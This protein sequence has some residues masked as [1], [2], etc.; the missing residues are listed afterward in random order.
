MGIELLATD[1]GKHYLEGNPRDVARYE[2]VIP[3]VWE[4]SPECF[5][6][7]GWRRLIHRGEWWVMDFRDLIPGLLLAAPDSSSRAL[8]G[9]VRVLA[10]LDEVDAMV[11]RH[12]VEREMNARGWLTPPG[13]LA[14]RYERYS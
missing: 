7:V 1:R 2:G 11:L 9:A 4:F 8:R 6:F 14:R 3:D 10:P 13:W 12:D 5:R